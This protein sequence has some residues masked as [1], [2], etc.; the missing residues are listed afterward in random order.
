MSV[1]QITE[2]APKYASM[3]LEA[4]CVLVILVISL[5]QTIKVAMVGTILW[6]HVNNM[7]C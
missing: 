1:L 2:T 7:L 4:T 6:T 5:V 3:L